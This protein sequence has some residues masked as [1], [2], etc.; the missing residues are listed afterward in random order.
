ME[1]TPEEGVGYILSQTA[2]RRRESIYREAGW[3]DAGAVA[4]DGGK[5]SQN[6]RKSEETDASSYVTARRE[7]GCLPN[8]RV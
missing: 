1:D 3:I 4:D 8:V 6:L 5:G 2:E 7:A